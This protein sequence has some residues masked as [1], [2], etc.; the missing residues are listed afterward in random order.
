MCFCMV[1]SNKKAIFERASAALGVED[2][3]DPSS[4]NS[5]DELICI[6]R[7]DYSETKNDQYFYMYDSGFI[8]VNL[9]KIVDR[10]EYNYFWR[11]FKADIAGFDKEDVKII[12]INENSGYYEK[13]L[14]H[15]I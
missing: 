8:S 14:A 4:G 5:M 1:D 6:Y 10:V 13:L 3:Y 11:Y 9:N 2:N 12:Y 7:T 15:E